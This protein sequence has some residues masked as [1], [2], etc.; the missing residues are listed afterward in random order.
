MFALNRTSGRR[1]ARAICLTAVAGG[2]AGLVV[3]AD[4]TPAGI[5]VACFLGTATGALFGWS[6]VTSD[7]MESDAS[8][9]SYVGARSPDD[10]G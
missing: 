6:L 10:S 3:S 7:P 9:R 2:I 4:K 1:K 8:E 5:T